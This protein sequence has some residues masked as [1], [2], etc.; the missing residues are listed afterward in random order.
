[1]LPDSHGLPKT[2]LAVAE[3][4]F[5]PESNSLFLLC[6][7]PPFSCLQANPA[8]IRGPKSPGLQL[9]EGHHEG[10][11]SGEGRSRSEAC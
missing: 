7:H 1:M 4:E 10:M 11:V 9:A 8:S 2:T 5:S 3:Q 6:G